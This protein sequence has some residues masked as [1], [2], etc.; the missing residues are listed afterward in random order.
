MESE[1]RQRLLQ[2]LLADA[3]LDRLRRHSLDCGLAELR[4]RRDRHQIRRTAALGLLLLGTAVAGV[5]LWTERYPVA[6]VT[7]ISAA[8][9]PTPP[10]PATPAPVKTLTDEELFALFPGRPLAL[11]GTPGHQ[12]LVFLDQLPRPA[13]EDKPDP[14]S[15]AAF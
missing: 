3:D 2:E 6:P 12:R 9:T 5:V 8:A 14:A 13:A 15:A 4:A 7:A 10:A 1:D 11:V